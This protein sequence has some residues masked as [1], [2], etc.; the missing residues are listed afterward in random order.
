MFH[1]NAADV[2]ESGSEPAF[3][4]NTAE[5]VYVIEAAHNPEIAGSNPAPATEKALHMQ[6]FLL[7][8]RSVEL[9]LLPNFCSGSRGISLK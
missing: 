9:G 3:T 1:L 2:G 6:G 7:L 8:G 4:R 5:R